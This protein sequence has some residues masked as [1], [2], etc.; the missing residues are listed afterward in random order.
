MRKVTTG[1]PILFLFSLSL[2][3][4]SILSAL[5][6][7]STSPLSKAFHF[8]ATRILKKKEKY[9]QASNQLRGQKRKINL[10]WWDGNIWISFWA[11]V[12][13]ESL[14]YFVN[15]EPIYRFFYCCRVGSHSH[16]IVSALLSSFWLF[17]ISLDGRRRRKNSTS[18]DVE[19]IFFHFFSPL[20]FVHSG[21][22]CPRRISC[23]RP[24]RVY[25]IGRELCGSISAAVLSV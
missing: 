7:R 22:N 19:K 16:Q 23:H 1:S 20:T 24:S 14:G 12:L 11:R 2:M 6:M 25:S 18:V 4:V 8:P 3:D 15:D 10:Q 13:F 17:Y 9:F 21:V 5:L